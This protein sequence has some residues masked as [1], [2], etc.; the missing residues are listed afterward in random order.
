MPLP[1]LVD[2]APLL[3]SAEQERT[4]RHAALAGLS[5]IG[6][7]RL[8][9][10]HVAVI[11]AGG[12]GS[13]VIFALA[14]AGVG[15][16]TVID[17][18]VVDL[19]NLQRQVLHRVAD[20]GRPK[21][22]SAERVARDLSPTTRVHAHR[23][24]LTARNAVDLLRGADLVVDG[25]DSFLTR[26]AVAEATETLGVPLVWGALQGA[27]AQVTVFW[28]TPPVGAA[29]VVLDDLYPAGSAHDAPS[30]AEAG[31][32]GPLCLQVG[33]LLATEAVKLIAGVGEPLLGRILVVDAWAGTVREVPLAPARR[34]APA[35]IIAAG[36]I[37]EIE[38]E[39]LAE[40]LDTGAVLLDVRESWET[41]RGVIPGS[42]LRP[43][44]DVLAAPTA[45]AGP[46]GDGP[47]VVVCQAGG[48][49]RRAAEALRATGVEASVLRGGYAAWIAAAGAP[50]G[51]HT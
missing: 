17:D 18:D 16:L 12:L 39:R 7:R 4:L 20:L 5:E 36:D 23:E 8:A 15:T 41:A 40:K 24:R 14:A 42:V 35:P 1:P 6:Q 51:A 32:L 49:A 37:P 30:C 34:S 21:T 45:F 38:P 46:V 3:D 10:A 11:G 33:G 9:A 2:P 13:P 43:L 22:E 25:S 50:A 26:E 27:A 47:V 19:S 48:R 29:R 44:A 31:V 28:S